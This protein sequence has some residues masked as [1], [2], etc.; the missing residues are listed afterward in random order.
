MYTFQPIHVP[1]TGDPLLS[2]LI[3]LSHI[4]PTSLTFTI[5]SVLTFLGFSIFLVVLIIFAAI[6]KDDTPVRTHFHLT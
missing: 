4:P 1:L 2:Y 3:H 6:P 5:P